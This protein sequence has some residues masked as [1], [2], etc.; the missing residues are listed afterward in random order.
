MPSTF[1]TG[2][3]G[4]VGRNLVPALVSRGDRVFALARSDTAAAT[5]S[6]LGATPVRAELDD[7]EAMTT[8][9]RSCE[10]VFHCAAKIDEWGAP[11]EFERVNVAGTEAVLTAAK[12]AGVRRLVHVS[13]EAVL[14]GGGP[15]VDADETK[16]LPRR[17]LGQYARTKGLAE[18]RV[19]DA[20]SGTL[21]TVVVR[22][23]F[24]WGKGDTAV[25]PRLADAV[26]DGRFSWISGGR[27]RTSTCHVQNLV[28]AL[29]LAGER[30][31][32]G[33]VYFVTDGA[34]VEF[35]SFITALLKTRGV[36]PGTKSIPHAIAHAVAIVGD[37]AYRL[38]NAKGPPP[39][40]HATLHLIG[41]EV[42]VVDAKARRELEYVGR[43]T[44]EA[45]LAEMQGT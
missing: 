25:L 39:L 9:M 26:R 19:R 14:V 16:P 15:I 38:V 28:E 37:A 40:A 13:T 22:P 20:S 42:T 33:E 45:G 27:Y 10:T 24:V 36:D 21:T 6:A 18:T 44:R 4:F 30:G 8:A 7:V 29:L 11:S 2:G 41:E 34:P 3:S 43:V 12:R 31:R 17:P 35:R 32:G 5:V 23:R 1:L